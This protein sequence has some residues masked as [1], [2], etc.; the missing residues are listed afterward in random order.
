MSN[1][2]I[3]AEQSGGVLRKATLH[4]LGAGRELARRAGGALHVALL[5]S[6]PSQPPRGGRTFW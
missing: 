6:R 1:V 5:G 2:L 4:A 3:V